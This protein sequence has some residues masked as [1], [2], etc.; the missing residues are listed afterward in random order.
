MDT[1][2]SEIVVNYEGKG[3]RFEDEGK[4]PGYVHARPAWLIAVREKLLGFYFDL[5]CQSTERL[6]PKL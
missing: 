2:D 4:R 3:C 5:L 6:C 1:L